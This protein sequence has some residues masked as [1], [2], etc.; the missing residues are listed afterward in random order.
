MILRF[1]QVLF[2]L[3]LTLFSGC[4]SQEPPANRE[5]RASLPTSVIPRRVDSLAT[6]KILVFSKTVGWRHDSIPEGIATFEKMA[7]AEKFSIVATEDSSI[8]NDTDLKQFNTIVFLNTTLDVLDKNQEAAME[9]YIQAGGGFV[10]IHSAT[11]TEWE[12]DWFWFRNLVG[13]VFKNH[14]SQPSNVQNARLVSL[15]PGDPLLENIPHEFSLADEWYNYRD[16]YEGLEYLMEVD[17][18]TYQGGE[19]GEHHPIAWVGEHFIRV[20]GIAKKRFKIR[21]FNNYY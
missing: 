9:R 4:D 5:A 1:P 13:A 6:A 20:W 12:G 17:E 8:F 7:T 18:K 11:D 2:F 3:F 10:G 19:H 14:P 16:L 21:F 15:I